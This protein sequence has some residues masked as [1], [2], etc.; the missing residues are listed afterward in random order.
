[1]KL[2]NLVNIWK[3]K[4][5]DTLRFISLVNRNYFFLI[6]NANKIKWKQLFKSN[7]TKKMGK[8]LFVILFT[9]SAKH[10]V[11][12]VVFLFHGS[13]YDAFRLWCL[14]L[15]VNNASHDLESYKI[16]VCYLTPFACF[17][18]QLMLSAVTGVGRS[19]L[20][21]MDPSIMFGRVNWSVFL[22]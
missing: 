9:L 3:M 8:T 7:L 19:W 15:L 12:F 18:V 16:H 11:F 4:L 2:L 1:M 14:Q 21:C 20:V 13:F 22:A 10:T 6:T 17:K 5:F